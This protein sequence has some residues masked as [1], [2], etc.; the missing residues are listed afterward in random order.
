MQM[1]D[2]VVYVMTQERVQLSL[3]AH[4]DLRPDVIIVDEA[5]S[6]SEGAR[7]ILLQT[8]I[9]EML[10]RNQSAQ[11]LF[12][13]PTTRNLDVFGCLFNLSNMTMR[14]SRD[15]TVSQNFLIATSGQGRI[16]ITGAREN[17][18]GFTLGDVPTKLR[19][20][21]RV[22]KLAH[23]PVA[24]CRGQQ[25]LIYANGADE[26]EDIAIELAKEIEG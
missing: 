14:P 25:N 2:R 5:H 17:G 1:H 12:A 19:L 9:E 3:H 6:I 23:I 18:R 22:D 4:P 11:V 13:S 24:L 8:V 15:P 10:A 20:R 21:S 7:G 16:S 26:A